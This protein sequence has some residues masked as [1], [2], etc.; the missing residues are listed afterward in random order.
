MATPRHLVACLASACVLLPAARPVH[1]MPGMTPIAHEDLQ[2]FESRIRPILAEHCYKCHG[3]GADEVKGGLLLD[4]AQGVSEG[5]LSGPVVVPGDPAGSLLVT[6]VSYLD[7]DLRMPP[8]G[9]KLSDKQI[10]DLTE[11]VRR[12]APDPR[13]AVAATGDSPAYGGIGRRHWA[14][15]PVSD[16]GA[17]RVADATWP[18]TTVDHFILE[19]LEAAGLTPNPEADRRT[20]LRRVTFGLTGLPPDERELA[21]FVADT[22]PDAFEKVVDRLLASPSYGEHQARQWLDVV[23]YSDTKGDPPRREDP[24]HPHAWTYRDWV[25]ESFNTDLPY[26]RFITLQLAA[27]RVFETRTREDHRAPPKEADQTD[28]AALGFLTV[29]NQFNGMRN[30]IIDDRIDV[31]T[32][33]FLGLT[34][35]CARCHD[36]KFDPIPTEDYYSLYGV[37]ANTAVPGRLPTVRPVSRTPEVEDYLAQR[38]ALDA[39]AA[40]IEKTYQEMRRNRDRD[41]DKRRELIRAQTRVQRELGDLESGHPGAPP[42]AMA[43]VDVPRPRDHPVLI[44][45]EAGNRGKVV[46]RRFLEVLSPEGRAVFRDGSG[47]LELA[48]AIA[49]P[50]NPLTARTLVNRVWQAHFGQGIVPTPDDLGNMSAPPSHPGLLDHLATRFVASGWSIKALHREIVLSSAYRQSVDNNPRHAA[51]D[52][53][54]RLLWRANLRRLTFEQLHDALLL[55]GGTLDPARLG[56]RPVPIGSADFLE[57]RAVYTFIDRRNPAELFTQFDFPDPNTPSGRRHETIVPQ[58]ALFL[59]NSPMV[60][61]TARALVRREGFEA[62]ASDEERVEALYLAIFQRQ[63]TAGETTLCLDYLRANPG[64]A[65]LEAPPATLFSELNS[66]AAR[67]QARLAEAAGANP[68]NRRGMQAEPGGAAFTNREPLD[69]WTKLAHALFQSNEAM[70]LN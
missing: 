46:P 65:S 29:G 36:H 14:F 18:R 19:K 58:Q 52:P 33:A 68:M 51:I 24:R 60:I 6:A 5:G 31:T 32:K 27:D 28:L 44:R 57:R 26:D 47:R 11:W 67:R 30:D 55:I 34:V 4:S 7:E 70:F 2:F 1:A 21:G 9:R 42:R 17:P 49:D 62:L 8:K 53:D 54:N 63:P 45:G 35:S 37:F 25:I 22:S 15:Q 3:E 50:A 43:V 59:M 10:A 16:P 20:L 66:R 41:P 56:G 23:R 12:G 38:A 61:E 13:V 69:A 64:G 40:E 48:R 39:R